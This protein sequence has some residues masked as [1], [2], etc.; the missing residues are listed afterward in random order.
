[1]KTPNVVLLGKKTKKNPQDYPCYIPKLITVFNN[2]EV[3]KRSKS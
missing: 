1:M 2:D 3:P